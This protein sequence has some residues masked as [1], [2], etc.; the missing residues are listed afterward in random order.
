MQQLSPTTT[1]I[2]SRVVIPALR[3]YIVLA[4]PV[5]LVLTSVRLVATET[6]LRLEYHRPGFPTDPY[7]FTREDRLVY[8]PYGVRY[9]TNDAEI[10][11]LADLTID[12]QPAFRQKE[13]DHMQDVKVVARTAFRFHNIL[14]LGL[15][16]AIGLLAWRPA[17]RREMRFALSGGGIFTVGLILTLVVSV[18]AAWDVFF[19]GFH[20]VFFEGTSW[21][22]YNS[23]TLIR[24]YPEQFWFDAA[25]A[26]GIGTLSGALALIGAVWVYVRHRVINKNGAARDPVERMASV[27]NAD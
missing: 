14:T 18:L 24:L 16:A 12:D 17:T 5:F 4:M 2:L 21:R 22:F 13:L 7:G 1:S 26:I 3:W 19:D 6:F 15:I 23:D 9:M 25:L 8:G 10:S 11:Y 20:S 27:D